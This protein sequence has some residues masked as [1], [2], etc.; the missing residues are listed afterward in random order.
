MEIRKE[1]EETEK[2]SFTQNEGTSVPRPRLPRI[3]SR[4]NINAEKYHHPP[5]RSV[6]R[7]LVIALDRLQVRF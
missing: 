3:Y 7:V 6:P 1:Q 2:S 5:F 4:N